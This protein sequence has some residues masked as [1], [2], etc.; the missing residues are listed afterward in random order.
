MSEIK[1]QV[2][3]ELQQNITVSADVLKLNGITRNYTGITNDQLQ[4]LID[5][6][7]SAIEVKLIPHTYANSFDFPNIGDEAVIYIDEQNNKSYRWSNKELKYYCIG[8]DY[9]DIKIINGG[10]SQNG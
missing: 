3:A 6:K 4:V 1:K 5:N 8:S 9:N 2:S 10:D 7:E